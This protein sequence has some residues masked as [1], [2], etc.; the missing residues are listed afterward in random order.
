[1][2]KNTYR[3]K[4]PVHS[5]EK[6]LG[7]VEC[8]KS[9]PGEG[10]QINELSERLN[11]GKST[12]HRILDTLLAHQ[13]VEKCQH[14]KYR[15]G[16]KLFEI[17]NAIPRQRNLDLFD[18]LILQNLCNKYDETVNLAVC[19]G[20]RAVIVAK[21][22]PL[23]VSVK[24]NLLVGGREPLHATAIGKSLI[25]ELNFKELHA[26]FDGEHLKRYTQKTITS[27][28]ELFEHLQT[29][30]E[31][32][33]SI[34]EEEY[35]EGLTCIAVPIKNHRKDIIAA[36]SISGPTFRLKHKKILDAIQDLQSARDDMS[37]YFGLYQST[38]CIPSG[39]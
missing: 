35:S 4:Y 29:V 21:C 20:D 38:M 28:A 13:Y 31:V 26:I 14:S 19:I 11:L 5:L 1:L 17:G 12:V 33:Y 36:I 30:R 22:D 7:L 18:P 27:I 25:S 24:A 9:C 23:N 6:A 15:L 10:L 34:D 2:T 16:W 39:S 32:G 37:K 8:L 3:P